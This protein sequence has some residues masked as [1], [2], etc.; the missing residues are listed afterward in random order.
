MSGSQFRETFPTIRDIR[1]A[2]RFSFSR[3]EK[4][5]SYLNALKGCLQL[6]ARLFEGYE[7]SC[8]VIPSRSF[9]SFFLARAEREEVERP[10]KE[11]KGNFATSVMGNSLAHELGA[12]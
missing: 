3:R 8:S 11:E 6:S 7:C 1:E 4:S 10:E 2:S 12:K 5:I 9:F